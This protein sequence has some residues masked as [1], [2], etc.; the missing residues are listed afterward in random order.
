MEVDAVRGYLQDSIDKAELAE[1]VLAGQVKDRVTDIVAQANRLR[2]T[3]NALKVD[4]MNAHEKTQ[5]A[6]N[7]AHLVYVG[8]SDNTEPITFFGQVLENSEDNIAK[9]NSLT[10]W[11]EQTF[12][13]VIQDYTSVT[14]TNKGKLR[15]AAGHLQGYL[16]SI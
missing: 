13:T 9:I 3:L 8:S 1:S 15:S 16:N 7:S 6:R 12:N 10:D 2:E 14:E 11:L 5:W 4:Q